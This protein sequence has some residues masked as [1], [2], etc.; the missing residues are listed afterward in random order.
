MEGS[1]TCSC[2]MFFHLDENFLKLCLILVVSLLVLAVIHK[3]CIELISFF[4]K[5]NVTFEE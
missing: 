5:M 4:L 2:L 3:K 1:D